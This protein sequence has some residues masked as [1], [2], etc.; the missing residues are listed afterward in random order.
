MIKLNGNVCIGKRNQLSGDNLE[1][2]VLIKIN[3]DY[4]HI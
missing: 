3:K 2:E 4:L 1:R